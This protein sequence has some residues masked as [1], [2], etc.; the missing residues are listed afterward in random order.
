MSQLSAAGIRHRDIRLENL[1]VRDGHP[2]L[3]DFGWAETGD[4]ACLNPGGLGGLERIK[5]GPPC[6]TYSM[7]RVFEQII[8][9]NSKL[10]APL[11]QMM[12]DPDLARRVAVTELEQLLKSLALSEAWDVPLVFPIPRHAAARPGEPLIETGVFSAGGRAVLETMPRILPQ[13][14]PVI[15]ANNPCLRCAEPGLPFTWDIQ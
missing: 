6:D 7:G 8:P 13:D 10:F 1:R 4:E 2:A 15:T 14:I 5:E 9:Q 12:L 3:I 11:L